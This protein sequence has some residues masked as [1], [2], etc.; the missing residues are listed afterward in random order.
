MREATQGLS[1]TAVRLLAVLPEGIKVRLSRPYK[2]QVLVRAASTAVRTGRIPMMDQI[3]LFFAR[4]EEHN[5]IWD[6]LEKAKQQ[7]GQTKE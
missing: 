6:R 2:E 5:G 3:S 4:P 1:E 7:H